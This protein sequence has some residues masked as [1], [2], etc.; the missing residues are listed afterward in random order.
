MSSKIKIEF[1]LGTLK[2]DL[3]KYS[4]SICRNVA[5]EIADELTED[6]TFAIGAFY[7]DYSP[8]VYVRHY[9]NFMNKSY[10]RYYSNPHNK[11]FRGGVEFTPNQMDN[12]YQSK[13]YGS[14]TTI[15]EVFGSVIEAGSHGPELYTKVPP[16]K[17]S[18]MEMVINDRDN[19]IDKID[20]YIDRA[21]VK[22][23]NEHYTVLSFT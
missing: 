1:D 4:D 21:K 23:R 7:S 20:E 13:R 19:I 3:K 15:E 16:M 11:I 2:Q 22:A 8:D 18:P 6:T 10:R 5:S 14:N 9:Y 12:I 17:K